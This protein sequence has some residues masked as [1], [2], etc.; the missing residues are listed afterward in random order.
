MA[1]M[2]R[3]FSIRWKRYPIRD[4]SS[5][6]ERSLLEMAILMYGSSNSINKDERNGDEHLEPEGGIKQ[7]Q[8][9]RHRMGDISSPPQMAEAEIAICGFS[10]L[11]YRGGLFGNEPL[12][13][14]RNIR[15][16]PSNLLMMAA[17]LS[18]EKKEDRHGFLRLI[19]KANRTR[20]GLP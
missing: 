19:P 15:H 10:S 11:I 12:E 16:T 20:I 1:A 17:M 7:R 2:I 13:A 9:P 8:S 6:V 18:P 3:I 14:W 4:I 5:R